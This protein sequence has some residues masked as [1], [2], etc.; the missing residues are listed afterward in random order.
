MPRGKKELASFMGA[1]QMLFCA[2]VFAQVPRRVC[3]QPP[4]AADRH[5]TRQKG[6][7]TSGARPRRA[8]MRATTTPRE[9]AVTRI[10][11]PTRTTRHGLRGPSSWRGW[12]RSF[13][14][15]AQTVA[16]TSG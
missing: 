11:S 7:S 16:V 10:K 3:V 1:G 4:A 12:G 13:L 2:P 9:A 8:G 6:M 14:L 15:R 5:G